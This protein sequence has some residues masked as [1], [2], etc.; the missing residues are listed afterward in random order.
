MDEWMEKY[1]GDMDIENITWAREDTN[2]IFKCWKDIKIF[3]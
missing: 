1:T 2:F 3:N